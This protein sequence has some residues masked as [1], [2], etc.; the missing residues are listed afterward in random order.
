MYKH[1]RIILPTY[2]IF[3][4][5]CGKCSTELLESAREYRCCNEV[6]EAIGKVVFEGGDESC[7]TLTEN[8][9][10]VVNR[11]VLLLA[12]PLLKTREGKRYRKHA[13]ENE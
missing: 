9:K 10:A 2:F 6:H 1:R 7:L 13:N 12:A 4:C 11:E 8:F 5:S 3:R